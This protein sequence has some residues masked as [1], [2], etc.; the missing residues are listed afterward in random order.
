MKGIGILFLVFQGIICFG[1]NYIFQNQ[2][3]F[4][5]Y[6]I[7]PAL[8]GANRSG[9]AMLVYSKRLIG[10]E[11]A[12]N[13]QLLSIDYPFPKNQIGLGINGF[14]DQNGA[15]SFVG[16]E[17][18]FAYHIE[19][20]ERGSNKPIS[21]LSFGISATYNQYRIDRLG[22]LAGN[23][24]NNLFTDDTKF[25]NAYPNA[26]VGFHFHSHG[27]H[28]GI[29]A[30]NIIPQVNDLFR[31][32]NDVRNAFLTFIS[33][34]VKLKVSENIEITPSVLLRTQ[35]SADYQLD[36]MVDVTFNLPG[37]AYFSV[38][39]VYRNYEYA[40]FSKSRSVGMNAMVSKYP[41]TAGYQFDIGL[42][43]VQSIPNM[44]HLL[45]VAYALSE[46]PKLKKK[47]EKNKAA[48]KTTQASPSK[49]KKNE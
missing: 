10:F 41:F 3:Y 8:A 31:D 6:L 40:V 27:F 23:V 39:P 1:Q 49:Q 12:P 38:A 5:P 13:S 34:G 25:F 7:N 37:G 32:E 20:V 47:Q 30:Y 24:D 17:S 35:Q 48:T 4:K 45:I 33:S 18:T 46:K 19:N 2:H 15:V 11:N 43:R 26:N 22:L 29:S 14:K 21:G 28:L 44:G 36:M 42:S 9:N 16:M